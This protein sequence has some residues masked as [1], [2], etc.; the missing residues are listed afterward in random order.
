MVAREDAPTVR[1]LGLWVAVSLV[2]FV[3]VASRNDS[4]GT[5][6]SPGA[7]ESPRVLAVLLAVQLVVAVVVSIVVVTRRDRQHTA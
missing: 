5:L 3:V 7:G 2:A 6:A 4:T 1:W